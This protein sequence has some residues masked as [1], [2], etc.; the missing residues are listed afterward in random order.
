MRRPLWSRGA[1]T[2]CISLDELS[3]R[4]APNWRFPGC[5]AWGN[6]NLV[7]WYVQPCLDISAAALLIASLIRG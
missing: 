4:L 5:Q 1:A 7:P 2:W 3:P 6:A